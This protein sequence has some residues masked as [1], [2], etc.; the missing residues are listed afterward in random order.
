MSILTVYVGLDYHQ[1]F[2][3]VCVL[4]RE[5]T[6]LFNRK[7]PN[8]WRAITECVPANAQVFA[9]IEACTGAADLADELIEYANWSVTLAHAT[10]VAHMKKS[11]DKTDFTDAR[12]LADLERVGYLPQVWLAPRKLRDLRQLVRFRQQLVNE[13]RNVKLRVSALLRDNRIETSGSRWTQ[14][15]IEWLRRAS[16]PEQ[17]RWVT[18]RHLEQFARLNREIREVEQ[19]LE[20]IL[21]DDPVVERLRSV[22]GIGLVTAAILRA[23]IGRFDRFRSGKQLARFCGLSPKNMSSGN[24]QADGGLIRAGNPQIRCVL[25]EAAQ[26]LGRYDARW[27]SLKQSLMSRGKPASVATAAVANR[28]VRWLYHEMTKQVA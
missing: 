13:R 1:S 20:Q 3:Q 26:R 19:H 16:L 10:Y 28:W 2:V 17:T 11:P 24:K 5:G 9:A 12:L 15:W 22:K 18:D 23:E 7:C 21:A 6:T 4:D 14:P 25:I 27:R 8:S